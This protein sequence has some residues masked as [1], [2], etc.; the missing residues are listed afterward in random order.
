[1]KI[2]KILYFASLLLVSQCQVPD[3]ILSANLDSLDQLDNLGE[4]DKV[5]DIQAFLDSIKAKQTAQALPPKPTLK[6]HKSSKSQ[7]KPKLRKKPKIL[8]NRSLLDSSNL[9]LFNSGEGKAAIRIGILSMPVHRNMRRYLRKKG[10]RLMARDMLYKQDLIK[11]RSQS[12]ISWTWRKRK[13]VAKKVIHSMKKY[14]YYPTSYAK[15]FFGWNIFDYL[16]EKKG[17]PLVKLIRSA[18]TTRFSKSGSTGWSRQ[19]RSMSL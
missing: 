5:D 7:K 15:A 11:D 8:H 10:I 4:L 17:D 6:P 13:Q 3:P 2:S 18:E 19:F 14:S 12:F 9:K 1:M 16:V